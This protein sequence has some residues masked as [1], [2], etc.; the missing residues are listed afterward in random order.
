MRPDTGCYAGN[1]FRFASKLILVAFEGL[2][3]MMIRA[4]TTDPFSFSDA[5]A[6][7]GGMLIVGVL[8][9]CISVCADDSPISDFLHR[10]QGEAD[11]SRF[12]ELLGALN[13][14]QQIPT[15]LQEHAASEESAQAADV[16]IA[17]EQQLQTRE[18]IRR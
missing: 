7:V 16:S 8:V 9:F 15:P 2:T 3:A 10:P 1:S 12:N 14:S 11:A 17:P 5:A 13:G 18:E 4:A 6:V